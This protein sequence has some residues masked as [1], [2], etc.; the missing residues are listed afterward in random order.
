MPF[1]HFFVTS[2]QD[3]YVAMATK[4]LEPEKRKQKH[5]R[6]YYFNEIYSVLSEFLNVNCAIAIAMATKLNTAEGH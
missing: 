2:L 4:L 1:N 3:I 6:R 5:G